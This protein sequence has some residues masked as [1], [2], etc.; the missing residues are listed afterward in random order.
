[1]KA[2]ERIRNKTRLEGR[3]DRD[4]TLGRGTMALVASCSEAHAAADHGVRA[5]FVGWKARAGFT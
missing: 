1:M 2:L 4:R 5:G 3:D